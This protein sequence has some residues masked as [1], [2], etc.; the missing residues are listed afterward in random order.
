MKVIEFNKETGTFISKEEIQVG[1]AT[2]AEEI[3]ETLKRELAGIIRQVK[4][5]KSRAEEIKSMLAVLDS[6]K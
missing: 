4:V 6:G 3:R 2:G 5:L 1:N